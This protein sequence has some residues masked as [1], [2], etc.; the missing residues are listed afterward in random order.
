MHRKATVHQ[1]DTLG[2]L[3]LSYW[4]G[5]ASGPVSPPFLGGAGD[6]TSSKPDG[7]FGFLAIPRPTDEVMV[8]YMG[9]GRPV[10]SYSITLNPKQLPLRSGESGQYDGDGQRTADIF[11]KDGSATLFDHHTGGVSITVSPDGTTLTITA[12]AGLNIVT[13]GSVKVNGTPLNVP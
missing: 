3:G 5:G 1:V 7:F 10:G 2:R 8:G 12:P 11:H 4:D 13:G 6:P 9:D